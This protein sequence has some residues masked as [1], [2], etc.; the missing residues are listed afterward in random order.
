MTEPREN[1]TGSFTGPV[2]PV[3]GDLMTNCRRVSHWLW[4]SSLEEVVCSKRGGA[5]LPGQTV[6][7]PPR[8]PPMPS[9]SF[10]LGLF[11]V[12]QV[13]PD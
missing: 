6:L 9:A 8:L 13:F 11:M 2:D 5:W 4:V 10:D 3:S 12:S 1:G 7:G